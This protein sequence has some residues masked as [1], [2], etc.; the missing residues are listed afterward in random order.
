MI[1]SG[2]IGDWL[3]GGEDARHNHVPAVGVSEAMNAKEFLRTQTIPRLAKA[4]PD[5][6]YFSLEAMRADLK[7]HRIS[8][9]AATL[10]RYLYDLVSEGVIFDAGRGWYSTLAS[11][12][13]LNTVPVGELVQLLE[14]RFPFLD[15]A[16]WSTEQIAP[17]GHHLLARFVS[18]VYADK[19]AIESVGEALREAGYGVFVNPSKADRTKNFRIK[20]K[21]VVVLPQKSDSPLDGKFAAIEKIMVDLYRESQTF[22]LVDMHEFRRIVLNIIGRFRISVGALVRYAERRDLTLD[23]FLGRRIN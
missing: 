8:V 9:G 22:N 19:D 20:D 10:P 13:V 1:G 7:A 21:T 6:P 16:A 4:Y 3:G 11:S 12:F 2:G 23:E 18:F 14:P 15:F 5:F 17:Y